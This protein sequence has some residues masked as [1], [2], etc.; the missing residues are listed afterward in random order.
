MR[1]TADDIKLK[2]LLKAAL[3]KLLEERR[4][5]VRDALADAVEDIGLAIEAGS[6]S[7]TIRPIGRF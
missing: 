5:L 2:T 4:D 3:V 7:K 1:L 6:K